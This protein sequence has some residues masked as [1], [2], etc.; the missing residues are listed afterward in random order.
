MSFIRRHAVLSYIALTFAIS[1][2]AILLVI[3]PRAVFDT[4][5]QTD[6]L[7]PVAILAMMIG[8]FAAGI[9]MTAV[10]YGREG[11]R[12]LLSRALQWRVGVRWYAI[13]LLTAPLSVLASLLAL[14]LL[15]PE[16]VPGI[17]AAEDKASILAFGLVA[18]LAVGLFEEVGWTGFATPELRARYGLFSTGLILGIVWGAW[19]LLVNVW[20]SAGSYGSVPL[21]LFLAVVLFSFLPPYRVLMV[22]VYDR[23]GSLLVVILM[24]A[25]LIAFWQIF[26]PELIAGF[27]LVAWYLVWAAV[28]WIFVAVMAVSARPREASVSRT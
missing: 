22:W 7:L 25:S 14:A 8:P 16:F 27:S 9:L 6:A 5:A 24:H 15:S 13:A 19:H 11:L 26:T 2:G 20:G 17:F 3:G 28:L 18:G 23:T 1:W 21:A 10:V 12:R 4:Q